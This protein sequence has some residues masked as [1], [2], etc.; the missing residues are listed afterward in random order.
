M[1]CLTVG[2]VGGGHVFEVFSLSDRLVVI[3]ASTLELLKHV[4]VFHF[5]LVLSNEG[6]IEDRG[7]FAPAPA[8]EDHGATALTTN[9]NEL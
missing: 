7:P 5:E 8:T 4:Y 3:L 6:E 9:S 1:I 2:E